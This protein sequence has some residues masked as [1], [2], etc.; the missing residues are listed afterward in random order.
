MLWS[1]GDD[2]TF[3]FSQT[4]LPVG[5]SPVRRWSGWH[6]PRSAGELHATRM[7]DEAA[8]VHEERVA[9]E[10]SRAIFA[11]FR[12]VTPSTGAPFRSAK[13]MRTAGAEQESV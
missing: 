10:R 1:D 8:T 4:P 11:A 3:L 5:R 13:P 6:P 12:A 7:Q 2:G 9:V